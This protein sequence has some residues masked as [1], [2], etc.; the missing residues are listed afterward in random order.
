MEE[1]LLFDVVSLPEHDVVPVGAVDVEVDL[2]DVRAPSARL[3]FHVL[4]DS[5]L[6]ILELCNL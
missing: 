6:F 5:L 3:I 1:R 2:S 4:I